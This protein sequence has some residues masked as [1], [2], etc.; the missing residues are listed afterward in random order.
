MKLVTSVCPKGSLTIN[1]GYIY[2]HFKDILDFRAFHKFTDKFY[3][4][5]AYEYP[6]IFDSMY[7]K[8]VKSLKS[9]DLEEDTK[10]DNGDE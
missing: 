10:Q 6:D 4:K 9:K 1:I 2:I 3:C 7:K 5:Y 8:L